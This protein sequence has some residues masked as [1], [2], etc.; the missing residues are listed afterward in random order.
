M[1]GA[2][3]THYIFNTYTMASYAFC[4]MSN[5][6]EQQICR[7]SPR[8]LPRCAATTDPFRISV[9]SASARDTKTR[10][11]TCL[12]LVFN[13]CTIHFLHHLHN[14]FNLHVC[15]FNGGG[16]G[17]LSSFQFLLSYHK[18][19]LI[20]VAWYVLRVKNMHS[21]SPPDP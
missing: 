13:L 4:G 2:V 19:S 3:V 18:V 1:I 5:C 9:N 12:K 11:D 8:T 16:G 10:T 17:S 15:P 14:Y 20:K 7:P 6:R 21:W